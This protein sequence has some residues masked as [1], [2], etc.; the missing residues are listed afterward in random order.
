MNPLQAPVDP[1]PTVVFALALAVLWAA[2][3]VRDRLR[4]IGGRARREHERLTEWLP[5]IRE[6]PSVQAR[7]DQSTGRIVLPPELMGSGGR[8]RGLTSR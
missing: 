3:V 5:V 6:K 1:W 4:S 7:F 2:R 8:H